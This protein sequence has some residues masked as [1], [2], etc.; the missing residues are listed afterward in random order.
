MERGTKRERKREKHRALDGTPYG[1][2]FA[3]HP[4]AMRPACGEYKRG[5]S[6]GCGGV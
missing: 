6:R 5:M 3:A 2:Y 4:A 1:V